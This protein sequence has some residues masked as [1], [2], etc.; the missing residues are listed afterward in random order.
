MRTERPIEFIADYFSSIMAGAHVIMRDFQYVN[1]SERN[2][3]AFVRLSLESFAE[4]PSD[5]PITSI[6][7]ANLLRMLCPDFPLELVENTALLCGPHC[8]SLLYLRYAL[9]RFGQSQRSSP[10]A[11]P[12]GSANNLYLSTKVYF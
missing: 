8:R 3:W 12:N 7:L 4:F 2:R 9:D 10:H 1:A 5:S 6:E 11:S